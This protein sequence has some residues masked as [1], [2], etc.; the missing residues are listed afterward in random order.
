MHVVFVFLTV[1]QLALLNDSGTVPVSVPP[2]TVHIRAIGQWED[3]LHQ[4]QSRQNFQLHKTRA[5]LHV[6]ESD[7]GKQCAVVCHAQRKPVTQLKQDMQSCVS[8]RLRKEDVYPTRMLNILLTVLS[9]IDLVHL[10]GVQ[11]VE[12]LA[13]REKVAHSPL[14]SQEECLPCCKIF[15]M[16]EGSGKQ[17]KKA[18]GRN[19]TFSSSPTSTFTSASVDRL[20]SGTGGVASAACAKAVGSAR[21]PVGGALTLFPLP[22][23]WNA[24]DSVSTTARTNQH[25]TRL[26]TGPMLK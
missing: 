7:S 23:P 12:L 24:T 9:V 17:K 16:D 25:R 6:F 20:S 1:R 21:T 19:V 22:A 8:K 5:L 14:Q 15:S 13:Q 26:Q 11:F 10:L 3:H 4:V 2:L 18:Q